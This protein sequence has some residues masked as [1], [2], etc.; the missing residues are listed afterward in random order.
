MN[1][2]QTKRDELRIEVGGSYRSG[3][4]NVRKRNTVRVVSGMCRDFSSGCV[5]C[6]VGGKIR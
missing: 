4:V 1:S 2:A 3:G 5:C 6:H